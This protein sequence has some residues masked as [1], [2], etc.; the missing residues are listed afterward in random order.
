MPKNSSIVVALRPLRE[1]MRELE[2]QH[3]QRI[4]NGDNSAE[5]DRDVA[6]AGLALVV[7][8]FL[9]YKIE[10]QPLYRLLCQ[11]AALSGGASP[12]R[13]LS[14]A[15]TPHRRPDP[16]AIE[17]IKGRL[18]AIMEYRQ[19]VGLTRK[20]AAQWV[21]RNIPPKMK[22]SLGAKSPATVD[23]W[24]LKWGGK[25]GAT[26]GSGRDGYLAMVAIIRDHKPNEQQLK[27]IVSAALSKSLPS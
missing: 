12:S 15:K 8:F 14:P 16:P 24:L 10:S 6:E 18:A 7:D 26:P 9:D 1:A 27:R 25:R 19:H 13:M 23:S 5:V 22:Q 11:L 2:A 4:A 20:A 3:T 21:V 17:N